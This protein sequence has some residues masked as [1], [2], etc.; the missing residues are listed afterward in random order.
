[1][2]GTGKNRSVAARGEAQAQKLTTRHRK[3]CVG[4]CDGNVLC[5]NCGGSYTNS[6]HLAK[7]IELYTKK[8]KCIGYYLYLRFFLKKVKAFNMK[9]DYC[10][11]ISF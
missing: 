6:M 9:L 8:V 11:Y 1:M 7:S 3:V 5:C 4:T 2:I 10:H